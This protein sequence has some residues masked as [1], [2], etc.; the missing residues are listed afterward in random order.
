MVVARVAVVNKRNVEIFR[1]YAATCCARDTARPLRRSP[2]MVSAADSNA[3]AWG[4]TQG[5]IHH[6]NEQKALFITVSLQ[7]LPRQALSY[8]CALFGAYLRR[9]HSGG[10]GGY[11]GD[12]EAGHGANTI[13]EH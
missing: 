12:G 6:V 1:T 13:A 2:A 5:D 9:L 11:D 7:R 8:G 10:C 3:A 4:R